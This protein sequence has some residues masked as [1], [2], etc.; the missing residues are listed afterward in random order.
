MIVGFAGAASA[1]YNNTPGVYSVNVGVVP[2][3]LPPGSLPGDAPSVG[4]D[5][6]RGTLT[7]TGGSGGYSAQFQG[8]RDT[9]GAKLNVNASFTGSWAGFKLGSIVVGSSL[10]S[11][12]IT[13]ID[14]AN[15]ISANINGVGTVDGAIHRLIAKIGAGGA[16]G[17][18]KILKA[19]GNL[20]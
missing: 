1:Q 20:R 7:V 2:A 10:E 9:D 8:K 13:G 14:S 6:Y 12:C 16:L 11:D 15:L 18:W 5:L 3:L 17:N 19:P 4:P